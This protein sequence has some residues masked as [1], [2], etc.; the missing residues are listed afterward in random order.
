MPK[1]NLGVTFHRLRHVQVEAALLC[2]AELGAG[3]AG[4]KDVAVLHLRIG[5]DQNDQGCYRKPRNSSQKEG[6]GNKCLVS[7]LTY[8]PKRDHQHSL[9]IL[10][11]FSVSLAPAK[12][13]LPH[14]E[15]LKRRW[16]IDKSN[17]YPC[18]FLGTFNSC[19]LA[20]NFR[21]SLFRWLH[22]ST[23]NA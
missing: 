12:E 5:S 10:L 21:V 8:Q 3:Q 13:R 17:Q 15:K 1:P 14:F 7:P 9:D 4:L 6:Q 11:S 18:G 23:C 16:C 20:V 22:C 19:K 2:G